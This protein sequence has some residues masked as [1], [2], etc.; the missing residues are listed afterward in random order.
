[1]LFSCYSPDSSMVKEHKTSINKDHGK[2]IEDADETK[3]KPVVD[4]DIKTKD[5]NENLLAD[6]LDEK[7]ET[8]KSKI[9][10]FTFESEPV[11]EENKYAEEINFKKISTG[12]LIVALVFGQS[13][14]ANYGET[15]YC[16]Q[17][18]VY[19]YY[20][21]K[22]YKAEDPLLGAEGQRGS[23]WTRLGDKL[24]INGIYDQ[25]LFI[26]LGAGG[27]VIERWTPDGD[28]HYRI[29]ESIVQLNYY[30]LEITHLL[31]HQGSANSWQHS[32]ESAESYK[33]NFNQ[34]LDSIRGSGVHAPI[35][36]CVSTYSYGN[37]DE[38]IRQ[39]QKDLVDIDNKIYPGPNTDKLDA[40]LRFDGVHFSDEGLEA[41]ADL[42]LEKIEKYKDNK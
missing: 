13:Q 24:I 35:Y 41:L 3:N 18:K 21:G 26:P 19:S 27:S 8:D 30:D 33:I 42:W 34:M 2:N 36:V 28:L 9:D 6:E 31:W 17:E 32:L 25:V 1:M 20:K 14:S 16:S 4:N 38:F 39:A 7:N 10:E 12:N 5:N 15:K 29:D 22:F 37:Y 40:S 11:R 23:V